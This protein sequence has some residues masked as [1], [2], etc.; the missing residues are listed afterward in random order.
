MRMRRGSVPPL[1]TFIREGE[2]VDRIPGSSFLNAAAEVSGEE[3]AELLRAV[4]SCGKYEY[5][6][7]DAGADLFPCNRRMIA[8]SDVFV[9]IC[10]GRGRDRYSEERRTSMEKLAGCVIRV[11]NLADP[12]SRIPRN[13]FLQ[14]ACEPDAFVTMNGTVQ[15]QLNNAYGMDA[16]EIAVRIEEESGHDREYEAYHAGDPAVAQ[17]GAG[18]ARK[19]GE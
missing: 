10:S 3:M 16:A 15:I 6:F 12:V 19:D 1:K 9:S 2:R 11:E 13:G 5:V 8:S 14:A 4:S 7:L 17:A 18:T